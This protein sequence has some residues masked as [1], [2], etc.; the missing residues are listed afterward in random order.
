MKTAEKFSFFY[1]ALFVVSNSVNAYAGPEDRSP[2]GKEL[3]DVVGDSQQTE[4]PP[5]IFVNDS[6]EDGG[7][8]GG[9]IKEK[10]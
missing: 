7:G 4:S 8:G 2:F 10:Q 3:E 5:I 9:E 1:I 6:R